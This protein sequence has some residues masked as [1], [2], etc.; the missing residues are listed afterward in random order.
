MADNVKQFGQASRKVG[1]KKAA[2]K[3]DIR[4]ELSARLGKLP[5]EK[6]M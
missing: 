4:A 6:E 3:V 2:A 5:D 1:F